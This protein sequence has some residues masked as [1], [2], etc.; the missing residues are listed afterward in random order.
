MPPGD[1]DST[2]GGLRL[3][4][5][6]NWNAAAFLVAV[7]V[8]FVTL[9]VVIARIGID[10]FGA[11]GIF[12]GLFAPLMLVG[13]VVG[14]ASIRE[15]SASLARGQ[16]EDARHVFWTALWVCAA[17][18]AIVVVL[19]A[20]TGAWVVAHFLG[21]RD[22]SDEVLR[23]LCLIAAAGWSAQQVVNVLQAG[24]TATQAFRVLALL[25]TASA[26]LSAACLLATTAVWQTVDG[27][28]M[29]TAIGFGV[30]A[31]LSLFQVRRC[32]PM[33]FPAA[34]LERRALGRIVAFGRWQ[35]AAHLAGSVALQ[36]DR[37][38]LG[39]VSRLHIVGQLNVA[40]R[41]QEVVYMGVLKVTEVLFPHFAA[42]ADRPVHERLPLL[43]GSSW[44]TNALAAAALAPLVPLAASL[45]ELWVGPDAVP[46]G[47]PI[48]RTLATAGLVG[49]GTNALL[50]YMLSQGQ[51]DVLAR[52]NV[53][54]ALLVVLLS[55]ALLLSAGP[56]MA[57]FGILVA[58]VLRLTFLVAQM[59]SITGSTASV[60][61]MARGTQTP[62][63]AGLMLAWA[64]WP[65]FF[66]TASSWL[67]LGA[68][69]FL[70]AGATLLACV[71]AGLT[72]NG[73][74]RLLLGVADSLR[75]R[76][77]RS[78]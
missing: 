47:A 75:R 8:N 43:V 36:A 59:P 62:I 58:N 53:M 73:S 14:Q 63:A 48:L 44:L 77:L 72:E 67:G 55:T 69:Y 35:A 13:T 34:R 78:R 30:T 64:P 71:L 6:S 3:V 38:V 17:S 52:V 56:A 23:R 4:R 19:V 27:F 15:V 41:L 37:F 20:G 16:T 66:S 32:A 45:I 33:L 26:L 40:T 57:G 54:H 29:G 10:E 11:A 2:A 65:G 39:A 31:C 18:C 22:T 60:L 9:P 12:I 1:A 70:L 42:T 74:R 49:S 51:S 7:L 68:L 76:H 24:I 5:N 21:E 50:Y 61:S 28:L 25:N 46:A